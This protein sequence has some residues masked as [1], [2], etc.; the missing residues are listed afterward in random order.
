M[1]L[2]EGRAILPVLALHGLVTFPKTL[3]HLDVTEKIHIAAVQEAMK[4]NKF[5]FLALENLSDSKGNGDTNIY[6]V[7][8]IARI[9]QLLKAPAGEER[10]ALEVFARGELSGGLTGTPFPQALVTI[11]DEPYCAWDNDEEKAM[12]RAARSSFQEMTQYMEKLTPEISVN[13]ETLQ[14]GGD[15]ADYIAQNIPFKV[16]VK[17]KMLEEFDPHERL[18]YVIASIREETEMLIL[19]QK[20]SALVSIKM[21]KNQRDYFIREQIRTLQEELGDSGAD[22]YGDDDDEELYDSIGEMNAPEEVKEKLNKEL[23]RLSRMPAGSQDGVVIR[24]YIETCLELPWNKMTKDSFS[25][26]KASAILEAD[27]YGLKKVKERIVEMLAVR[28]LIERNGD[29]KDLLK[30]QILCLIGPPGTGKTSVAMSVA[31]AMNRK[32]VRISLGGVHDEAE[33]RGHRR[34]YI[35]AMPG[36][37]LTA[38]KEAKVSNPVM[39]LDEIDKLGND[40]RGDPAS[41]LLEVLDPEQNKAFRD[42]YIDMPY[43]LSSVLFITTANDMDTIP[44][45]LLDRMDTIEITSYTQEEKFNIAKKHLI[46]KQLKKHGLTKKMI[47]ITDDAVNEMIAL[48]TREAGVRSL[49]RTIAALCR[50]TAKEW[51]STDSDE[52]RKAIKITA[53]QLVDYLGS[54]K[55]KREDFPKEPSVGV[56]TGLAY[57]TVGGETMPIEVCAMEG[58]GKIELTGSLGDVMKESAKAAISYIRSRAAEFGI[59][60]DFYKTKDIHVHV[61]E[62][63]VPKDGPSAGITL[64]TALYSE[65]TGKKIRSDVAMTG[66]ITLRGHVLPIGGLRE[67]T[68]AAFKAGIKTVIIPEENVPDLYDVE[69]AVK[70]AVQFIP[71]KTLDDVLKIAVLEEKA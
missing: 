44:R 32:F 54:P 36:K 57:T 59:P 34:T 42:N 24:T 33:I 41:A 5:V 11:H 47:N 69:D 18:L 48:Y 37:I 52:S 8:A 67:K 65:L 27:H 64:A 70:Q 61:P 13:V 23:D 60:E 10:A 62:G 35:G 20:V 43:D 29:E 19:E 1:S 26:D 7:G 2:Y 38:L 66:E 45:P 28:K 68:M 12:I 58:T 31:R 63:A 50:K 16:D 56:V 3:I 51:L 39:L 30:T 49:E 25:L 71:A 4:D 22:I 14:D 53:K 17:Q 9:K 46:P 15:L 6:S 55:F 21:R 40:Y